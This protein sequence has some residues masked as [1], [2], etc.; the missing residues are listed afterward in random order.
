MG[1]GRGTNRRR[2]EIDERCAQIVPMTVQAILTVVG[3]F[4]M[5]GNKMNGS[6]L[7]GFYLYGHQLD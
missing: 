1:G 5:S 7:V 2:L 4:R 6:N 3:I